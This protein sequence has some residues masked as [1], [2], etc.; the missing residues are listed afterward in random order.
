MQK[1]REIETL[2]CRTSEEKKYIKVELYKS[3]NLEMQKSKTVE[4]QK[5]RKEEM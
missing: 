2:I 3:I 1:S 5:C 4:M